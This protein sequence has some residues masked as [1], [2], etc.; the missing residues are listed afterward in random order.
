[1]AVHHFCHN[2]PLLPHRTLFACCNFLFWFS[3]FFITQQKKNLYYRWFQ[4]KTQDQRE[5]YQKSTR[6]LFVCDI[7]IV[8]NKINHTTFTDTNGLVSV[9]HIVENIKSQ[10]G[11]LHCN[12]GLKFITSK[13]DI[14]LEVP[15]SPLPILQL[16][17][18]QYQTRAHP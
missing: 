9:S 6:A 14:L 18:Q 1:M 5:V 3:F 13:D 8:F 7:K 12:N 16:L 4:H 11:L 2:H 10:Q 15:L 17:R